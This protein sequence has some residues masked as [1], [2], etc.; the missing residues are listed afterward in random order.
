[1]KTSVMFEWILS[2]TVRKLSHLLRPPPPHLPHPQTSFVLQMKINTFNLITRRKIKKLNISFS[3]GSCLAFFFFFRNCESKEEKKGGFWCAEANS[4]ERLSRRQAKAQSRVTKAL[5]LF[6]FC[7]AQWQRQAWELLRRCH[8]AHKSD[9]DKALRKCFVK[10][11]RHLYFPIFVARRE[12]AKLESC[13]SAPWE[14]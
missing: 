10:W 4:V 9:N 13:C 6:D 14:R 1:M 2:P 7:G 12:S 11:H 5:T 3:T 8:S